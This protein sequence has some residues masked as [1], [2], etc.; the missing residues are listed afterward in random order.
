MSKKN[1]KSRRKAGAA[2][3]L[4]SVGL[5]SLGCAKNLVDSERLMGL[6]AGEGFPVCVDP[7]EADVVLVNTCA[8]IGAAAEEARGEIERQLLR[9]AEGRCRAVVVLGCYPKRFGRPARPGGADGWFGIGEEERVAAFL[10]E[11]AARGTGAAGE[12]TA[13]GSPGGLE[14]EVGRLRFTPEHWTYL[15]ITEGCD[16]R[17]RYCTI[18][19]IRGPMRRKPLD[20]ILREAEELAGSGARE[21]V[22]IGQDTAAWGDGRGRGLEAALEALAGVPGVEWL[23]VLYAHPAHVSDALVRALASGPPVLPYLDLPVQ[24]ASDRVLRAMGRPTS[25]E[26]LRR[27]VGRLREAVPGLTLR[28]TA[29]VGFPGET[30]AEFDELLR[31]LEWARFERAGAFLFSPEEGTEAA[32]L[33]GRV[34]AETGR[35]RLE[36]AAALG[37]A[38]RDRFHASRVGASTEAFVEGRLGDRTAART[39]AEAPE[40]DPWVLLEERLPAGA[41]GR[42]RI[43]GVLGP[44]CTATWKPEGGKRERGKT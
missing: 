44:D 30:E 22:L 38:L 10:G 37:G 20:R 41:R 42:V 5:V 26:D 25:G 31:F 13:P 36:V 34:D 40:T 24:H 14:A 39:A 2:A 12:G 9:K 1:K 6:L 35:R 18:P 4:P 8:F 16:N 3:P 27:L 11:W 15:R 29:M 23:R 43:T 7:E 28:T 17:C 33:P 32:A 21:F 19:S